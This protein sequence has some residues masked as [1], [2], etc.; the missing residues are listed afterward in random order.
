MREL[1]IRTVMILLVAIAG[2][3]V[4]ASSIGP[5]RTA[6]ATLSTAAQAQ[7]EAALA[8]SVSAALT[9]TQLE[10]GRSIIHLTQP[11]G[12]T[13]TKL[14]FA[15]RETDMAIQALR[16]A[17]AE[18]QGDRAAIEAAIATLAELRQQV[19]G[20]SI[21]RKTILERYTSLNS[22]MLDFTIS[23]AHS[24]QN[25]TTAIDLTALATLAGARDLLGQ[26]RAIGATVLAG[27][28]IATDAPD[29]FAALTST[30]TTV[31]GQVA[32]MI[33]AD[34]VDALGEL[35]GS[36]PAREIA[37]MRNNIL[38]E[39]ANLFTPISPEDWV[40]ASTA[41]IRLMADLEN[42][43]LALVTADLSAARGAARTS[44]WLTVGIA[45][46]TLGIAAGVS[47]YLAKGVGDRLSVVLRA[48]Q[49]LASGR[50]DVE[51]PAGSDTEIGEIVKGL[52]SF[53]AGAQQRLVLEAAQETQ[54]AM[55]RA[56]VTEMAA[57]LDALAAGDLTTRIDVEFNGEYAILR[58]NFNASVERLSQTIGKALLTSN[59]IQESS[60]EMSQAARDLSQ[61]TE[62]QAATLEETAAALDELTA[63]V[64]S[65]A[66]GAA[67][68]NETVATARQDAERS[69]EVVLAA[70]QSMS[71]IE[72]SSGEISQIIGVIQ[73]IAFQTNLLALNAG[74]EA[75]RAGE[76][77]RGFAVVA[78]EVRALAQ[79]SSEAAKD[80]KTLIS[81]SSQ[82]VG[83]GVKLVADAGTAL[84]GIVA[85]VN[86]ISE[87]IG[88]LAGSSR[89]QALGLSEI[90][91]GVNQLDQVT[92]QNAAMVEEST[93]A[94]ITLNQ[95]AVTLRDAMSTFQVETTPERSPHEAQTIAGLKDEGLHPAPFSQTQTIS[96]GMTL[97]VHEEP[98]IVE[99][100]WEEF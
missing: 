93:A 18:F 67:R 5:M 33:R 57:A 86:E 36:E 53:R 78:S 55:Q 84:S 46:A 59:D 45:L 65:A 23:L 77:G 82:H 16:D 87:L 37:R 20:G 68:A 38:N 63:S 58:E 72:E 40:T 31:L 47:L 95:Q 74:V 30:R 69:G 3:G 90:N 56:V 15:R 43:L 75:A 12:E 2:L 28:A 66:D 8:Q 54:T 27:N 26:E 6:L 1:K 9:R 89:E 29:L 25:A 48:I 41:Q 92:Q 76:A 32:G 17:M 11:D 94:S 97:R 42:R 4:V 80:I 85:Q 52:H 7:Y 91:T 81:D 21:P 49:D 22:S 71:A 98:E 35:V 64:K 62:A 96:D 83:T 44:L 79:R 34:L 14:Q 61:R 39:S 19:D 50:T 100:S 88:D 10:R 13:L 60:S 24:A 73:D 99:D 51:L 70:V